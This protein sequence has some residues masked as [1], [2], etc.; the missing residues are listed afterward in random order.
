MFL[1]QG[2]LAG[3]GL[4][5]RSGKIAGKKTDYTRMFVHESIPVTCIS[6][7]SDDCFSLTICYV[8]DQAESRRILFSEPIKN[9]L[10]HILMRA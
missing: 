2:S 3:F 1:L 6:V 7:F 5:N 10:G 9:S 8:N 4:S